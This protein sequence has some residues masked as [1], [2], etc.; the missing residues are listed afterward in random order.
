MKGE[1]RLD[2]RKE[3]LG[4][5][6]QMRDALAGVLE[7]LICGKG[8]LCDKLPELRAAAAGLDCFKAILGAAKAQKE[9]ENACF[10]DEKRLIVDF[11]DGFEDYLF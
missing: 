8:S 11:S 2:E 4:R 1:V 9:L 5:C 3:F 7:E 10:S 6:E